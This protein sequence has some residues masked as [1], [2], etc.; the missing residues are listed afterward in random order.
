MRKDIKER[1]LKQN[2]RA[3][4]QAQQVVQTPEL[5]EAA[6]KECVHLYICFKLYLEPEECWGMMLFQM[7]VKSIEQSIAMKLPLVREGET[8]V[9]CGAASSEAMKIALLLTALQKDFRVKL[10][11]KKLGFARD[12]EAVGCMVWDARKKGRRADGT[13]ESLQ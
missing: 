9:T 11:S 12:T 6:V 2:I 5:S 1:I 8:A 4:E 10:D 3:L 13:V 7:A